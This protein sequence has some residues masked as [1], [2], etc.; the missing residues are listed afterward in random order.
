MLKLSY[1]ESKAVAKIRKISDYKRMSEDDLL[2]ALI[3][4]QK[5]EKLSEK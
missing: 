1:K 5:P 2:K 3:E 4:S